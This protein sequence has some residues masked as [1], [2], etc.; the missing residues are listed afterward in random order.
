MIPS[1][2]PSPTPRIWKKNSF[3]LFLCIHREKSS[4]LK[5]FTRTVQFYGPDFCSRSMSTPV[6]LRGSVKVCSQSYY[7]LETKTQMFNLYIFVLSS[8]NQIL[9]LN[10]TKQ[11]W[12]LCILCPSFKQHIVSWAGKIFCSDRILIK[13]VL[14]ITSY[15]IR[16]KVFIL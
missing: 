3:L 6:P 16:Q 14:T 7:D 1:P 9:T 12:S 8:A 5:I 11:I 10:I 2:C 15:I 4:F 13:V